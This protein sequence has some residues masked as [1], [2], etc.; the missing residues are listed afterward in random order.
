MCQPSK[1]SDDWV[2]KGCHIHIGGVELTVA[3]DHRGTVVFRP[4]FSMTPVALADKAIK[5]ANEDCLSD[6]AIRDRWI[7]TIR[8]ATRY[9]LGYEGKYKSLAN[10]RMLK[11]KFLILAL[12]RYKA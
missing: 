11:F 6:P 12:Q 4:F 3:P 9:M 10:G 1:V 8:G 7:R 5:T 2:V